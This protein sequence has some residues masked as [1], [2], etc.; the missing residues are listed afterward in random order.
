MPKVV[1]TT[2]KKKKK[3]RKSVDIRMY[4]RYKRSRLLQIRA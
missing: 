2:V 3:K 4:G 1:V